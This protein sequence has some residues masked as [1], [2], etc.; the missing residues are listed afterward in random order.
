[1]TPDAP[2]TVTISDVAQAAGV[3]KMT[4]SNVINGKVRVRPD[5]RARVEAAIQQ[6]GYRVNPL[7]RALAGGA[8][9][10]IGVIA[11]S[12]TW[13]YVG[14]VIHGASRA[15]EHLGY[16]LALFTAP[17]GRGLDPA[18]RSLLRHLAD[19]VMLVLPDASPGWADPA[20][21]PEHVVSIDGPGAH[22]LV[23]DHAHGAR[24]A[25]D[26]LL[27]LGHRRIAHIAGPV[28]RGRDHAARRLRGYRDALREAG[29]TVRPEDVV[30][31]TYSEQSGRAAALALLQRPEAPSAI[32]AA[33]DGMAIGAIHTA[34]DLGLQVPRDL[35]VIGFDDLPIATAVR[36]SLTTVR[37]PLRQI[38]AD[39]VEALVRAATGTALPARRRYDTELIVRESTAPPGG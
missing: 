20:D 31:G 21:L 25:M 6:T 8:R 13:P 1:M 29:L 19:G 10:L 39:A 7:A 4:V 36:P 11:P 24:L 15:A 37:Q 33:S 14:E 27:S 3:S 12:L 35:S 16:S 30:R 23:V 34:L 32:F 18:R 26:H 38:G 17:L 2:T 9:G 22:R 5:T 28:E